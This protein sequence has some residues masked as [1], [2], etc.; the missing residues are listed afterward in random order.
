M[1]HLPLL[2]RKLAG[3]ESG[4]LVD[5]HRR[6][7]LKVTCLG[8][9]VKEEVDEGSLKPCSLSFV[10]RES[11]PGKLYSEVE[12]DNVEFL[13]KFPVRECVRS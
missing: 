7:N 8:V 13:C 12:V 11:C 10:N 1:V 3:A 9:D 5:H 2:V 4:C 6:F